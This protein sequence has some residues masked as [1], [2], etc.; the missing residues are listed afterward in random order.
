MAPK[1]QPTLKLRGVDNKVTKKTPKK[2]TAK[3]KEDYETQIKVKSE[4]A[5]KNAL[6]P[7][8]ALGLAPDSVPVPFGLS[9]AIIQELETSFHLTPLINLDGIGILGA[10]V[11]TGYNAAREALAGQGNEPEPLPNKYF[12]DIY[13]SQAY[14]EAVDLAEMRNERRRLMSPNTLFDSQVAIILDIVNQQHAPLREVRSRPVI[15]IWQNNASKQGRARTRKDDHWEG[16]AIAKRPAGERTRRVR[17]W[18]LGT[19]VE[20]DI[21]NGV[22][23]VESDIGSEGLERFLEARSGP[24]VREVL[25]PP[26]LEVPDGMRSIEHSNGEHVGLVFESDIRRI[27]DLHANAPTAATDPAWVA[28]DGPSDTEP[29]AKHNPMQQAIPGSTKP[30]VARDAYRGV[31]TPFVI[32]RTAEI[33]DKLRSSPKNIDDEVKYIDSYTYDNGD[34]I[35]QR[36]GTYPR[37]GTVTNIEGGEGSIH[38]RVLQNVFSPWG[39]QDTLPVAAGISLTV[40]SSP[41]AIQNEARKWGIEEVSN[42]KAR[43]IKDIKDFQGARTCYLP[44]F[45]VLKNIETITVRTWADRREKIIFQEG[46]IILGDLNVNK[47]QRQVTDFE[48]YVAVVPAKRLELIVQ[49]PALIVVADVAAKGVK[50]GAKRSRPADDDDDEDDN[51]NDNDSDNDNDDKPAKKAKTSCKKVAPSSSGDDPLAQEI[52]KIEEKSGTNILVTPSIDSE[53]ELAS[54]PTPPKES[55]KKT[56]KKTTTKTKK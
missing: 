19:E 49:G 48:G 25:P 35:L 53:D 31:P 13:E 41:E 37:N 6:L 33:T 32:F 5:P 3:I 7:Y 51:D 18:A 2:G 12:H 10:N 24:F 1:K 9:R 4:K 34:F 16:I 29:K 56:P 17:S 36:G 8:L 26:S 44:M 27:E 45:R 11:S 15:W 38:N 52:K 28:R 55:T 23:I 30:E 46:K 42:N 20:N 22:W 39:L 21:K 14:G 40:A 43:A 54:L 50:K 47:G